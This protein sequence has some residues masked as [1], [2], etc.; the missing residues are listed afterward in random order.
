MKK[1]LI[2][3]TILIVAIVLVFIIILWLII[4]PNLKYNKN[5]DI[6]HNLSKNETIE[7][8]FNCLDSRNPA[9]ANAVLLNKEL[10]KYS[11][12]KIT[13]AEVKSFST[14]DKIDINLSN[15][16]DRA[17]IFVEFD[18]DYFLGDSK[19]QAF[20][21]TQGC[22]NFYLVKTTEESDWKIHSWGLG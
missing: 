17:E 21:G 19:G 14:V 2:F 20:E 12:N 11:C 10:G 15:Y 7:Y 8:Y 22:L 3:F 18:C 16:Y 13:K 4:I 6:P 1:K 9:K 5:Y